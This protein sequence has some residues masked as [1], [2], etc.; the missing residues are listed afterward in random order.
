MEMTL[1]AILEAY[2]AHGRVWE[3]Q[4]R[5]RDYIRDHSLYSFQDRIERSEEHTSELQSRI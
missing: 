3:T 5:V 2:N 1:D 4:E